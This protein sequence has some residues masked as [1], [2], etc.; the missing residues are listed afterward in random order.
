MLAAFN[1]F[2][3]V[4]L[5]SALPFIV[6]WL[7]NGPFYGSGAAWAVAVGAYLVLFLALVGCTARVIKEG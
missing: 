7:A 4:A 5:F 3:I 1:S 2:Q 6:Q